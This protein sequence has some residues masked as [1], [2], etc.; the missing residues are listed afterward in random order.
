MTP[1]GGK[2]GLSTTVRVSRN[3]YRGRHADARGRKL[4]CGLLPGDL[5]MV[6]PAK[7]KRV[8]YILLTELYD[9]ALERRV[10]S[11]RM[12]KLNAKR[13]RK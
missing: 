13:R 2:D 8:E 12:T 5:I 9:L 10:R 1:F 6:R 11:E 7:T 3:E 4:V